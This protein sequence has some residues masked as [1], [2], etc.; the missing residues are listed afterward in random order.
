MELK[1]LLIEQKQQAL[2][3]EARS[4]GRVKDIMTAQIQ[5]FDIVLMFLHTKQT[6]E[7]MTKLKLTLD[8][9][10]TPIEELAP[11]RPN[12]HRLTDAIFDL[13]KKL[14]PGTKFPLNNLG[15]IKAK[16]ISSKI[17]SL[18]K[19][20]HLP[21]NIGPIKRKNEMYLAMF[22]KAVTEDDTTGE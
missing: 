3:R 6:E 5:V 10:A 7:D 11:R 9:Q 1:E 4:T 18:R 15:D 16:T 12:D 22:K 2:E 21:D 17:Y 13:V 14:K 19:K 8:A 20:G